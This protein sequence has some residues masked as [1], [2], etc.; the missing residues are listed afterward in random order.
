MNSF[1]QH[2]DYAD[3]ICLLS[4]KLSYLQDM[5]CSL[6]KEATSAGLKINREKM[7]LFSLTGSVKRSVKVP[8]FQIEAVDRFAYLGSI[9]AAGAG[10]DL[11]IENWINKARAAFGMLS[12]KNKSSICSNKSKHFFQFN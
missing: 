8:S 6:E 11:D 1:L 10:T 9:I 7:K 4:R 12:V 5:I 3:D 2:L